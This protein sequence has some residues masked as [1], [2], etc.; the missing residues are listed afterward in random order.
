[1]EGTSVDLGAESSCVNER[2]SGMNPWHVGATCL[3]V[4]PPLAGGVSK[5]PVLVVLL[6]LLILQLTPV[7]AALWTLD[8]VALVSFSIAVELVLRH[9]AAAASLLHTDPVPL[10]LGAH[11][12]M[13]WLRQVRDNEE[14]LSAFDSNS[15][16]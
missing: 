2:V 8:H 13:L 14:S 3:C 5:G 6:R 11:P 1:M 16:T 7:V 9:P 15:T 4:L 10:V 12:W